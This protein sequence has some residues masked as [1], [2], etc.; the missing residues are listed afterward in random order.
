MPILADGQ[1]GNLRQRFLGR[2][3]KVLRLS[4]PVVTLLIPPYILFVGESS[5]LSLF[6]EF[7][8][9][10]GLQDQTAAGDFIAG[11]VA[12]LNASA[13]A[14]FLAVTLIC[15]LGGAVSMTCLAII[16][17]IRWIDRKVGHR[18]RAV[19]RAGMN[20]MKA[21]GCFGPIIIGS[22]PFVAMIV[23][24]ILY[25]LFFASGTVLS[26]GY[27]EG[28]RLAKEAKSSALICAGR[29]RPAANGGRTD[30]VSIITSGGSRISGYPMPTD[31]QI[32]VIDQSGNA[33]WVK[34]DDGLTVMKTTIQH[35]HPQ[36]TKPKPH[37]SP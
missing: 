11:I 7:G 36:P 16:D 30:C 19:S 28:M 4:L 27:E 18:V 29:K 35:P 14:I 21:A 1:H 17:R 26:V 34:S 2:A 32:I 6:N 3:V 12:I 9:P 24:G 37:K 33:N 13:T 8:L 22:G 5:Q 25:G 15:I 23:F 31:Q 10:S 20:G